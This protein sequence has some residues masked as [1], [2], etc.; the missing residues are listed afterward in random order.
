MGILPIPFILPNELWYKHPF[1]IS[2]PFPEV[3]YERI[4][5]IQ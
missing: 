5:C 4:I 1:G 3:F 2:I